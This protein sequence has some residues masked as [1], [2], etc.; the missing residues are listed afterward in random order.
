MIVPVLK[1]SL[2][3]LKKDRAEALRLLQ[4]HGLIMIDKEEENL[5]VD[6]QYEDNLY[7]RVQN[8]LKHLKDHNGKSKAFGYQEVS[9]DSFVMDKE[10]RI[11]LLNQVEHVVQTIETLETSNKPLGEE[12]KLYQA[13]SL[14]TYSTS[15][16]KKAK[17][18]TFKYGYITD[19]NKPK[20]EEYL[21]EKNIPYEYYSSSE[22]GNALCYTALNEDSNVI[23]D[24]VR[25]LGFEEVELPLDERPFNEY[26]L[27]LELTIESNKKEIESLNQKLV[28]LSHSAGELRILAD[29][30]LSE[31][32]AKLVHFNETDKTLFI[33]GW[34][35]QDEKDKLEKI[36]K[37]SN[38]NYEIDFRTPRE[39]EVPPTA[40]KNNKFVAPFE[41]ITNMFSVPSH[42]DIDPNP[43]MSVWFWL[44]FGI[45]MGDIGYGLVLLIGGL[46]FLKLKR[47]KGSM[48]NLMTVFTLSGITSIVA[49]I[50]FDSFFGVSIFAA[51]GLPQVQVTNIMERPLELLVFSLGL[52]VLHIISGQI[53]KTIQSFRLKDPLTALADGMSW[54]FILLGLVLAFG[55]PLL[56]MFFQGSFAANE[57]T[58]VLSYVGY[59]FL[60]VGAL[61][62]ILL[63]GRGQKNPLKRVTSALGGLY[64]IANYLSDILS[65]SRILALSLSTAVIGYA[66]NLLGSMVGPAFGGFGWIFAVIIFVIGHIF[67]F[68]M[69]LLSAYVHDS[70]LQY[71]EFFGK[72][73]E[74]NGYLFEPFSL[75][76]ENVNEVITKD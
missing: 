70:R 60:G 22:L 19:K 28:D 46:L 72:F 55:Q 26:L 42:I 62:I 9:Y 14:L 24:N 8:A 18:T 54:I 36:L 49:G 58:K 3:I 37:K 1:T 39:D 15:D 57:F 10:N 33:T 45:A 16:I 61:L 48:K 44:I 69:G 63:A 30:I 52:G 73:Y 25:S 31:K 47:P 67:N 5:K 71:I 2:V 65:Y 59:G 51:M 74:G 7:L 32:E 38:L 66:M 34:T 75:K 35:R 29:Q 17:Y 76:L 27:N 6:T 20:F 50:L 53:L 43:V 41:T 68:A 56:S 40:V 4:K 11:K 12:I 64:G 21:I 13:F 23:L